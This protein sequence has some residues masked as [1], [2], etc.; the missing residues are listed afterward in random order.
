M[1]YSYFSNWKYVLREMCR[2]DKKYPLYIGLKSLAAFF[3]PF[4]AAIIPSTAIALIQN[5]YN[6]TSFSMVMFLL[7]AGN[8]AMGLLSMLM[9][10]LL[11][12][13]NFYV[14]YDAVQHQVVDQILTMNY[15][16]L[17]SARGRRLADAAKYSYEL[18]W[19]G[20]NRVMDM[21]T[22]FVYNLLGI[23]VYAILLIPK[24]PWV[25]PVFLIMSVM[26]L[27]LEKK[28]SRKGY[29]KYRDVI[30]E[31][32][33][34][35]N[36]FFQRSTSAT[37]GKDIRMYRMEKW[38]GDIM[39]AMVKKRMMVWKRVEV[40]YFWP[41][42]S[43]TVWSLVRDVIAYSILVNQFLNGSLDAAAFTLYLGIITGFAG[44]LNGGNMGDGF[45]RA[46]SEMMRCNWGICDY[47]E[48]ME[49]P[50]PYRNAGNDSH[51]ES[52]FRRENDSQ[53]TENHLDAIP[54]TK[55]KSGEKTAFSA[56]ENGVIIEFRNV[57]FRYPE[58][59]QDTIHNLNLR[60]DAGEKIALVGVNGAG[61]TT[62]VKLLCGFYQPSSGEILVNGRNI[63]DYDLE[64]YQK[65]VGAVFQDM[66]VMATSVA[67]NIACCKKEQID[68]KRLWKCM[69]LADIADKVRGLSRK[70][71]TSVT[72]FLDKDGVLFSGGELQ[73]LLL[74][75]A[76]YKDAPMLLLDEPTSALDPLAELAVYEQYHKLS[77][78]KTTIFISH[79]LASTRF[80]SR[81]LFYDGGQIK[82][83]GSHEELMTLQGEYAEMFTLQSQYYAAAKG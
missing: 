20:W 37:D 5:K 62:L 26:N 68:R 65:Q 72:N 40:A 48:F 60:I 43:D 1:R 56:P 11:Q 29:G 52:D 12:K 24:C 15:S 75:R 71:D 36:Y 82:E 17:E 70:E 2:Y 21:I 23:V 47:R 57:C 35:V 45:V 59:E 13:K 16:I 54:I 64:E 80:C 3:G 28:I 58:A 9:D 63:W 25:L 30:R 66:M 8:F 69:E 44:W 73:R 53:E 67:E 46:Y 32:D 33:S 10:S 19:Q 74:A 41:C 7:V 42:L 50:K 78:N 34:K 55:N 18:D 81:I 83:D 77:E 14:S 76:L 79:R 38:F 39:N 31:T 51:R 61:K 4:L 6:V 49:Q 22:P 27:L